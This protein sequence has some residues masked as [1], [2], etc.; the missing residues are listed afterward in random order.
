M[1]QRLTTELFL[2]SVAKRS[3][4]RAGGWPGAADSET[5]DGPEPAGSGR[6]SSGAMEIQVCPSGASP[7]LAMP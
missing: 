1:I 4:G 5:L 2:L 3:Y 7:E 6:G